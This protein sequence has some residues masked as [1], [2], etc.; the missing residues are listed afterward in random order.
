MDSIV[1]SGGQR[2]DTHALR[3]CGESPLI[4]APWTPEGRVRGATG[5]SALIGSNAVD[6]DAAGKVRTQAIS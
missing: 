3:P 2:T 5:A 6:A 4:S 1:R